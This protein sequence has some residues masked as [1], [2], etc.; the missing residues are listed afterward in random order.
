MMTAMHLP[1]YLVI[2]VVPVVLCIVGLAVVY[3]GSEDRA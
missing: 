1:E 3:L 2:G